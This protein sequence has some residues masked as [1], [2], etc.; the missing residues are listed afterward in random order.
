MWT[1][2]AVFAGASLAARGDHSPRAG[3][4]VAFIS[5]ASGFGWRWAFLAL[6]PGPVA[7]AL[8]MR[9]LSRADGREGD[10][11]FFVARDR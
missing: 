7:G 11:P 2:I 8:V 3:S 4:L 5:I 1:W 9:R 10:R 6:V